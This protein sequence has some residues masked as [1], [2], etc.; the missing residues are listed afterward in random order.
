MAMIKLKRESKNFW[1]SLF[2]NGEGMVESLIF[3]ANLTKRVSKLPFLLK[4][5]RKLIDRLFIRISGKQASLPSKGGFQQRNPKHFYK[6][7]LLSPSFRG[8]KC[9]LSFKGGYRATKENLYYL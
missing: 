6:A 1:K 5:Q 9:L 7:W 4:N 2:L 8:I 3:V